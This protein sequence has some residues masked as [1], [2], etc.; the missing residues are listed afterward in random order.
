MMSN[1]SRF[2]AGLAAATLGLSLAACSQ[3]GGSGGGDI[4][5]VNGQKI[6]K[7]EFTAK[8]SAL[9][10]AKAVLNQLV[11]ADLVDQYAK[12]NNIQIPDADVTKKLDEIKARYPAGQFENAVK[13]QGLSETDVRNI[14]RQQL[15]VERAVSK[16]INV[17][18]ADIKKYFDQ[19][20]ATLDKPAQV[21]ARHILVADQKTADLV[22]SK[23]K[24]GAKFEDLAKQYSVDPGSKDKGGDLGFFGKGQMVPAFEQA[25]FSL[26]PNQVSAP[27]KS[28]F[29]YHVIQV[30]EF[31]PAEKATLASSHD[32][33]KE[34]LTQ[35][36]EQLQ[37]PLFLQ[38]L[39]SKAKIEVYDDRYK[40]IV[41]Q[42]PAPAASPAK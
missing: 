42:V 22:E 3:S 33:I 11:Q 4:A 1:A 9:P 41:P 16:D 23:L 28:P 39:R 2:A 10:Q 15:I 19:N 25:A 17:T 34:L 6:T 36:Q 26:Q 7:A 20:H 12:D 27:V 35:Q 21:H 18:D 5:S 24:G 38:T 30:V 29:G 13:A 31:K 37:I 14:I 32:K 8:L 40:D